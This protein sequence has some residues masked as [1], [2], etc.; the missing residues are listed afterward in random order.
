[1]K[2]RLVSLFCSTVLLT[3]I[4]MTSTV[5][6][7]GTLMT[8]QGWG[9]RGKDSVQ[10]FSI[11][12]TTYI[13]LTHT[14]SN[15]AYNNPSEAIMDVT[16]TTKSFWGGWVKTPY[17]LRTQGNGTSYY[18]TNLPANT[19]KLYFNTIYSGAVADVSGRVT[20]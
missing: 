8:Y 17:S 2:K 15:F 14:N 6:A 19:Y 9:I 11:G 7:A 10:S 16:F 12:S 5:L 1:M 3:I 4:A 20:N 13:N 18:S